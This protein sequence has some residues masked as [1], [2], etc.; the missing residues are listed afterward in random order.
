M[1]IPDVKAINSRG[2]GQQPA[3]RDTEEVEKSLRDDIQSRPRVDLDPFN[4]CR[5]NIPSIVQRSIMLI[6]LRSE[7][8]CNTQ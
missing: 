3:Q 6:F 2:S 4:A 8:D 5:D 7:G 1:T